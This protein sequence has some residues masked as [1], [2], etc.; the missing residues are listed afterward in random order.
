[1]GA[2]GEIQVGEIEIS[3]GYNV[4]G[5]E[6]TTG[7]AGGNANATVLTGV[8]GD[9]KVPGASVEG[10]AGAELSTK[11]GATLGVKVTGH[12]GPAS[13]EV[14]VDARGA[15]ASAQVEGNKDIKLGA[16][17]QIGLGVGITVNLSQ[18]A[19][20]AEHATQSSLALANYVV[21]KLMPGGPIF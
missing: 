19:R 17:A 7:L 4:I 6:G 1:M 13:G 15:H 5:V 9:A 14:K 21:N 16:H 12:V 3:G 8:Q 2:Q 20:A 11:D 10:K 18:A